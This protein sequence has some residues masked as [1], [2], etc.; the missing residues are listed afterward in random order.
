MIKT[1]L[2]FLL[3]MAIN[4]NILNCQKN[5]K[6]TIEVFYETLCPDSQRFVTTQLSK[7]FTKLQNVTNIVLVPYGKASVRDSLTLL[8]SL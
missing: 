3:V 4:I 7:I 8:Y 1:K 5:E 6:L 2:L